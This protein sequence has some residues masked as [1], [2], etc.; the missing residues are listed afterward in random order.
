MTPEATGSWPE[1]TPWED[2]RDTLHLWFQIVGKVRLQLEPM[3][4]HW[5]QVPLYVSARG[6]GTSLMHGGSGGP[7]G[8]VGGRGLEIEF[9]FLDHVLHIRTTL[10]ATRTLALEPRSVA[11]FYSETMAALDDLGVPVRIVPI[12]NE[13][14]RAIPFAEDSEHHA[15]D[16][17]AAQRFWLAL[18]ATHRVMERF[19]GRF[20]GKVSPIH[21]F[22][23]GPD[24]AVTRFSGRPAPR[25]P[26][27]VPHCPDR[28]QVQAYSHEVSSCGYWPGGGGEGSFYAYAYPEPPGFA[29]WPVEPAGA[30]YVPAAGEFLLPYTAVR[31]AGDPDAALLAF[32][33]STYEAAAVR[34]NWDRAALEA[35]LSADPA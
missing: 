23:G 7:V 21:F 6:L 12:P 28:V 24:L 32:F 8:N 29:G 2:T 13:V 5:W 27:G 16:P 18:V 4:N 14:E 9:D 1:L 10:G 15:Y 33:Q 30:A 31:T 11:S 35:D 26:G 22:W 17:G 25:H 19:R 3:V 34:G 20:I